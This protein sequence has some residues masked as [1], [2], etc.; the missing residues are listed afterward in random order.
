MTA[1]TAAAAAAGVGEC[2]GRCDRWA[3]VVWQSSVW[4]AVVGDQRTEVHGQRL[5]VAQLAWNFAREFIVVE[6]EKG[7]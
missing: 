7:V 1:A 2:G 6:H 5:H 4:R 3:R